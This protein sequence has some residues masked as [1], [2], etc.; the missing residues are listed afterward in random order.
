MGN[1]K[2][3]ELIR[4]YLEGTATPEEE[5]LLESWYIAAARDQASMSGQPDYSRL[6]AEILE[7]LRAEQKAPPPIPTK[8]PVRLWPRIAAAAAVL[9]IIAIGSLY[10]FRKTPVKPVAQNPSPENDILPAATRAT[11]TLLDGRKIALDS[12]GAG[13]LARQ[14]NAIVT[15][16]N[17]E[18]AYSANQ[19]SPDNSY[20]TL[21]TK[22][23]EHYSAKLPD[24]TKVW[25]NAASSIT[26]PLSF[27]GNNRRVTVTGEC[28]FEIVHDKKQ[29]F[30]VAVRNQ[31]IEDI[32]THLNIKAY[33]DEPAITT[34]LLEGSIRLTKGDRSI[35]LKPGQQAASRPVDQSFQLKEVDVDQA[36]AWKNGYFFFDGADIR[37]VMRELAR[38]YNIQ[39]VYKGGLPKRRFMGKVYRNI[40]AEEALGILAYFGAHFH[41]EGRTVTVSS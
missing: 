1:E 21:T 33:D 24:G 15:S 17:G 14:G 30:R 5:A 36:V 39:V 3:E 2:A 40:K 18:L 7:P 20:N 23:G 28:Y 12:V 13:T 25:L 35:V 38:W 8:P 9:I 37:T 11:L 34:T 22:A 31:L 29:P 16:H 41:L 4:K 26:Y 6:A 10:V 19:P 27:N 32:G